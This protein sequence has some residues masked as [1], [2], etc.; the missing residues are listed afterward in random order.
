MDHWVEITLLIRAV[1]ASPFITG[2]G[3]PCTFRCQSHGSVVGWEGWTEMKRNESEVTGW[4]I[5]YLLTFPKNF[6]GPS[7]G[8]VWL[9]IAGVFWSSNWPLDWGKQDSEGCLMLLF[10]LFGGLGILRM[11]YSN[12]KHQRYVYCQQGIIFAAHVR[13]Y[14][15][16]ISTPI[17]TPGSLWFSKGWVL[18]P[19]DVYISG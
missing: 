14:S 17:M 12:Q 18:L 5:T 13:F 11:L 19:A 9:C 8:G 4:P 15:E 10:F 16:I 2:R 7:N 1:I 6:Q 3:T